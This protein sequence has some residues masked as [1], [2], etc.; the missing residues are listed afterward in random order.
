MVRIILFDASYYVHGG[1]ALAKEEYLNEHIP[2]AIFFDINE[3]ADKN[4][5][6]E[7]TIPT[8]E[9]FAEKVGLLGIN[10]KC[11]VVIYDRMGGACAASRVWWMFN[12]FGHNNTSIL[13]GGLT[14]WKLEKRSLHNTV[15]PIHKQT[16]SSI[17]N[18]NNLKNKIDVLKNIEDQEIQL[19]DARSKGRY[20]GVDPEPRKG[21]RSGHIPKSINIPYQSFFSREALTFRD[22]KEIK[23]IFTEHGVNLSKPIMVSCGSGVTAC[24]ISFC[25]NLIGKNDVAIYDG[26]WVE[27]GGDPDL[28]IE[29]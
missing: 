24:A 17:Y 21:L 29:K 22:S 2:N 10:N 11:H 5:D 20:K 13:D 25:C 27:W 23:N 12:L 4:S 26:S 18:S 19:I 7:H 1:T 6:Y 8:P 28:P 9:F 16:F 14:K 15:T 3:I